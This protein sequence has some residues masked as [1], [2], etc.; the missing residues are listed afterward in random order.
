MDLDPAGQAQGLRRW[1]ALAVTEVLAP[2]V[3]IV[4]LTTVVSVHA[5]DSLSQGL[6]VAALAM[7]FAVA[8]PYGVLLAGIRA[9]RLSDR[10]L[11]TREERPVMMAV[12]LVSVGVG[13]LLLRR[14][15]APAHV[16]ALM[17]AVGAGLAATLGI[18]TVWKISVHTSCVAGA[19]V[20]LA[21]LVHPA[22][23]LLAPLTPL[24]A[25]ARVV[26]GRHTVLQTVTGGVLGSVVAAAV[27]L[28]LR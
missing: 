15:D 17:A 11:R 2:A 18:S 21:L 10:H 27:L 25:W 13:L 8:L 3:L 26:L 14:L 23:W 12:A 5:S 22:A 16:F 19:V 28:P 4:V 9:G 6:R 1:L 7:L 20:S 24:T